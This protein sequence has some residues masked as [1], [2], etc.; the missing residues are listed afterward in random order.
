MIY[1]W[2]GRGRRPAVFI[3]IAGLWALVALLWVLFDAAWFILLLF[4]AA[5]LPLLRDALR[6]TTARI[7]VWPNRIVW[8]SALLDGE[9]GDI[10]HVRLDRRFDGSLKITLVHPDDSHTRLPPDVT[11]PADALEAA[12]IEAGIS[13]ERHPFAPF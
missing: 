1:A 7:E 3:A 9:R 5:S 6:D 11:P 10:D 8:A 4:I 2:E 13:A 12:L